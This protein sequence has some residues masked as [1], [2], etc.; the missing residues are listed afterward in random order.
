M[1][2][3]FD[4]CLLICMHAQLFVRS[5]SQNVP[6]D[7]VRCQMSGTLPTDAVVDVP[8]DL[9][10]QTVAEIDHTYMRDKAIQPDRVQG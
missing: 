9:E 6:V 10:A 1:N 7:L 4:A 2:A 3:H 5:V 8:T